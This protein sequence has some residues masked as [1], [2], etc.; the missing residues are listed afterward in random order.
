MIK[1]SEDVQLATSTQYFSPSCPYWIDIFDQNNFI[2]LSIDPIFDA[3][4]FA[5][6]IMLDDKNLREIKNVEIDKRS[7]F[8]DNL[9]KD[10]PKRREFF[11]YNLSYDKG[12][13]K[14]QIKILS[15]LGF[16]IK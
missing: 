16:L 9:R 4:N 12:I 3:V 1:L 11:N 6:P 7:A 2:Y 5:Y 8:F 15:N 14:E 13:N 10:Y